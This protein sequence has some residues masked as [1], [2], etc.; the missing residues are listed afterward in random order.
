MR[1]NRS[2]LGTLV[3]ASVSLM[4]YAIITGNSALLGL[5]GLVGLVAFPAYLIF[6]SLSIFR[7]FRSL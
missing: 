2:T 7:N 1:E 6:L 3:L 4:G 5:G